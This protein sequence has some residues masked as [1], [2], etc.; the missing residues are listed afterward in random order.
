MMIHDDEVMDFFVH[1][2]LFSFDASVF[3]SILFLSCVSI[4][5]KKIILFSCFHL[6]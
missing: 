2:F 6:S 1:G 3:F 5:E 4:L